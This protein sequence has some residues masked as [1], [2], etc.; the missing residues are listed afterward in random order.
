MPTEK[1]IAGGDRA[2]RDKGRKAIAKS[3]SKLGTLVV[4]YVAIDAIA[5]NTYNPNRQSDHD[6]ELLMRSMEE[7]GI[8]QPIIVNNG[9]V[10]VDGEHRWR[11]ARQIGYKE[12]PIVR[13]DM[14]PEQMR[15]STIRH[16]RA[17][18]SHD[19]EL[20]ALILRD[21]Q[22]LG[23]LDW[24]KDSLILDDAEV[25]N[26]LN[27][28]AA[29]DA[30]AGKEYSSAWVPSSFTD[31]QKEIMTQA[32][33]E[34]KTNTGGL[35]NAAATAEAVDRQREREALL[36]KA[37]TEQERIAIRKDTDTYRVALLFSADQAVMV[38][39]A[40]ANSRQS[41]FWKCVRPGT[42][43]TRTP[44]T[45]PDI[46]VKAFTWRGHHMT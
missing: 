4:E 17:R 43:R 44:A 28:I 7:D 30:L 46:H 10:I 3:A 12:I 31:G 1:I 34:F 19:I 38:K 21:L 33:Q 14:T 39:R 18:G 13:V 40:L 26:L 9:G 23:A 32:G 16:N 29:P 35:V 36:A 6:F 27:D 2:L 24:A 8:T 25:N 37:K 15:I 20:E 5:P 45:R 42:R 22:A 41:A 11:A